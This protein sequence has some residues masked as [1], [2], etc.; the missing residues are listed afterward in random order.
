[1]PK[2]KRGS[3]GRFGPRYGVRV[4]RRTTEIDATK[5]KRY[6]CPECN[7]E[8][9]RRVSTGIWRCTRCNNTF[10]GGAYRPSLSGSFRR[11]EIPSPDEAS[12]TENEE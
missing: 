5:S 8:S 2:K 6:V 10:A 1:M 12:S 3:A 4:R 11:E 9:L 7:H